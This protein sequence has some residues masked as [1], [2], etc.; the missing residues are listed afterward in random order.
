MRKRNGDDGN[1]ASFRAAV[2]ERL[3]RNYEPDPF[4]VWHLATAAFEEA[5]FATFPPDLSTLCIVAGCP[6]GGLV[7]DP[8][9]GAGTVGLS[10]VA[11]GRRADLIELNPEYARLAQAR[12]EAAYMG[13]AE[14]QHHMVRRLGKTEHPGP[15][16]A[17]ALAL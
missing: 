5:H 14:G 10:A 11:T 4:Q 3:L 1:A 12:I 6:K 17:E 13:K 9:A 15:L 16:F 8:F 2:E 7:L